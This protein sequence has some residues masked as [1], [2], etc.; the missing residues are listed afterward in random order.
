M[1]KFEV[2]ILGCGSAK[3]TTRHFPASQVVNVRDKLFM[4]DC[5]EGAQIQFCKSRLKFSRLQSIFISH[6]H[7]D[8]CLG[9][10]GLASTLNLLGRTAQLHVYLPKGG[11]EVFGP[12]IHYFNWEM[13]FEVVFHEF[14][15]KVSEV[16]Y[17]DRSLTVTTLPLEHRMPCCGFRFDEKPTP[18]HILREMIDAYEIPLSEI[19]RIKNGADYTLADGRVIAN[20]RLTTPS[21]PPRSYAYCS[22]TRYMPALAAKLQGVN[23]LYHEATFCEDDAQKATA[24]YH[25]TASQAA[26]VAK[27]AGVGKLII[28]H[29]SS[30]YDDESQ[31]LSEASAV[32]E[33][34][35]LAR[36]NL[37]VKI[38]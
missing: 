29:Y 19:N 27:E 5:G 20:E 4:I 36:E 6:L 33:P 7:A 21:D 18:R 15:D 22:D 35:I 24:R 25:S 34:T 10:I 17:E 3:P 23:L 12:V 28:G 8:H 26:Q 32:F 37:C 38:E 13:T 14:D 9:L 16:I 2:H 11:A 30:R 1:E 31:L